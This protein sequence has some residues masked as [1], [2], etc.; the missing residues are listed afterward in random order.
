MAALTAT[1]ISSTGLQFS[2]QKGVSLADQL[3]IILVRGEKKK[4]KQILPG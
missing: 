1:G 4:Y 3:E 2:S